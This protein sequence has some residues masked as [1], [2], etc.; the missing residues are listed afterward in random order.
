MYQIPNFILLC[1]EQDGRK[2]IIII[3]VLRWIPYGE[4]KII[5]TTNLA[6]GKT[7]CQTAYTGADTTF[8]YTRQLPGKD[9][10][11]SRKSHRPLPDLFVGVEAWWLLTEQIVP[12]DQKFCGGGNNFTSS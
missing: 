10:E 2:G 8:T 6:P 4:K 3:A 12:T 1:G 5:E 11:E 9:K 7:E